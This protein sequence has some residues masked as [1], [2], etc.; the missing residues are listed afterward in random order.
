MEALDAIL[1]F[2]PFNGDDSPVTK[3]PDKKI[4][5]IKKEQIDD[6]VVKTKETIVD[7][8]IQETCICKF[9]SQKARVID[10]T[11]KFIQ[12]ITI[13]QYIDN[14]E[15]Q[16][17]ISSGK[18]KIV[19]ELG[20]VLIKVQPT[21]KIKPYFKHKTDICDNKMSAW[22]IDWQSRFDNTE[23]PI[24]GR[25]TADVVVN[26]TILEF[27]HSP[28]SPDNVKHRSHDYIVECYKVYWIVDCNENFNVVDGDQSYHLTF[29]GD[30]WRYKSFIS[31]DYVY[32]NHSK[33]IYRINP[34]N[35]K[36]NMIEVTER[37][38][39]KEFI[40]S[41][42]KDIC[43][44]TSDKKGE[45]IYLN[46]LGAG[47]GKT[48]ASIQ[49]MNNDPRFSHKRIF[50][51]LTKMHSAKDVI[52]NEIKDQ[53]R[54]NNLKNLEFVKEDE[55]G[56]EGSKHYCISYTNKITNNK[57]VII[58][59]TI[60]S[61]MF[62][63]GNKNIKY[64][65]D[66]FKEIVKTIKE[67]FLNVNKNGTVNFGGLKPKLNKECLIVIDEAQD[68]GPEYIEAF[69]EIIKVTGIDVY[70]IG[71]KLQSIQYEHNIFTFLEKGNI[72]T[73]IIRSKGKN[74][75]MRF[76]NDHFKDF[77]NNVIDFE[78]YNLPLID[79]TCD[80]EKCE[81][82]HEKIVPYNI[83]EIP[84]IYAQ[85]PDD[86][87]INN[88]IDK[89]INFMKIEI[90]KYNYLP[91]NF[92]FIFPILTKNKLAN[93]L[94][95]KLQ[96][97]WITKFEDTKYQKNVAMK[98]FFWKENINSDKYYKYVF[99]H[100]SEEN[101]PINLRESENATRILSIH[102]SK[103]N[104]CEVVFL[105]GVS[106]FSLVRFSKFKCNLQYESLLHVAI[107]RQKKSLYIG[108][109]NN[110]DDIW[111]RFNNYTIEEDEN[112]EPPI[113]ARKNNKFDDMIDN[114]I[115]SDNIYN[116]IDEVFIRTRDYEKMM[117]DINK[118]DGIKSII[119]WGHHK[120][121]GYVFTYNIL[122]NIVEKEKIDNNEDIEN[123]ADQFRTILNKISKL[124]I[125]SYLYDE[126][127]KIIK[128]ISSF[129]NKKDN[130]I[131]PILRFVSK[132]ENPKHY[133]YTLII[134]EFIKHIQNK[135]IESFK[136][137]KM[138]FLCPLETT[139]LWH[140][141]GILDNGIYA[142]ISISDIYSIMYCYDECSNSL[143]DDH[144]RINNC[145]CTKK[146]TEGNKSNITTTYKEIRETIISHYEKIKQIN[147]LYINYNK[148]I[149]AINNN[150]NNFTYNV[151]H[152]VTIF[153]N[154]NN[155]KINC[156]Y[157]IISY[158]DEYVIHFMI[159]PTLN[160]LNYTKTIIEIFLHSY[161]IKNSNSETNNYTR[162]ND[163]KVIA[164]IMTLDSIKPILINV[165]VDKVDTTMKQC[166][167][168]YLINK[169][170]PFHKSLFNLYKYCK[171]NK[172]PKQSGLSYIIE[173]LSDD[174]Y[175][176]I[177]QYM[178]DYFLDIKKDLDVNKTNNNIIKKLN[179]QDI[180]LAEM[181]KYLEKS[182]NEFIGIGIEEIDSDVDY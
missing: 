155:F 81:Y 2:N 113:H 92:M 68:L 134:I 75:V 82:K 33:L 158:N 25:R 27:Q 38:T 145:I 128:D 32:L 79:K 176:K 107:T 12:I 20:N 135:I 78:K 66:A 76:H 129:A 164:C 87:K 10:N 163:K 98:D 175:D 101:Q 161:L 56:A 103:G 63:I 100:K 172:P 49:L 67:G 90:D 105:L 179:D 124:N 177:P 171:D 173:K 16:S 48:Y 97:F 41:I 83:F 65:R 74:H 35:V 60:D 53:L 170:Q 178:K 168:L 108:L 39:E 137:K 14:K 34:S 127:Y 7:E 136:N 52:L 24:G 117:I 11:G 154:N 61:F 70:V 152:K 111:Q 153:K 80:R 132:E 26:Q 28:L 91:K 180:F 6:F 19:C 148:C 162:Y 84:Q 141:I 93:K 95:A 159:Q 13:N 181:Q 57:N 169:Y 36:N 59:G 157:P 149:L 99:L 46:Q 89:I 121:R 64:G 125:Y 22:H 167:Y 85:D 120:I 142:E 55:I 45:T 106:E 165:D 15:L 182:A 131:I 43:I 58:L 21:Q 110:N 102:A 50:I 150:V 126:Y 51:Y 166:L 130:K 174:K 62:S 1:K 31:Q 8:N 47:A 160:K 146:F 123:F 133:K 94:E 72:S 116:I 139:I 23:I 88:V 30:T 112:I 104:G 144:T 119:D 151:S 114:I 54:K 156:K 109:V 73:P 17:D 44:F 143:D 69:N 140:I 9:N 115:E 40:E 122:K 118:N 138:P 86:K 18:K 37:K 3:Q 96:D 4:K 77:V 5:K 29:K 71:D 42:E 147:E